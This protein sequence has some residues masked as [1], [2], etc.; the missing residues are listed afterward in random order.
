MSGRFCVELSVVSVRCMRTFCFGPFLQILADLGRIVALIK[1]A[2]GGH[3]LQCSVQGS[4]PKA[5][6]NLGMRHVKPD[7]ISVLLMPK[8]KCGRDT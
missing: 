6:K 1:S 2:G 7:A 5:W 4:V 3:V 8:G